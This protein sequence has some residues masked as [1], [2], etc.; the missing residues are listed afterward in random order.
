VFSG[1]LSDSEP[2]VFF[3]GIGGQEGYYPVYEG[4][5]EGVAVL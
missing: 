3:K 4:V 1:S 2:S 5:P